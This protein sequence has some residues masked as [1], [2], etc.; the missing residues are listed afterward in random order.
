MIMYLLCSIHYFK[1]NISFEKVRDK[2]L[3]KKLEFLSLLDDDDDEYRGV[4]RENIV[5]FQ[6]ENN[7][8]DNNIQYKNQKV[9]YTNK[10]N[11]MEKEMT[12]LNNEKEK[13]NF[14]RHIR[15]RL[16][17]KA[18]D[19]SIDLR[20]NSREPNKYTNIFYNYKD[21]SEVLVLLRIKNGKKIGL[22]CNN[23][24]LYEQ[25]KNNN[26][27]S[28]YAGYIYINEQLFEI[29]LQDFF[30]KYGKYLQNIYDYLKSEYLRV[31]N[32]YNE[33]STRF[34]G[35]VDIFEIYQI[36]YIR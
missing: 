12:L 35:D 7:Y 14:K 20:Y 23:I 10:K 30:D 11:K 29:N 26:D 21:I 16:R 6:L 31:G 18:K 19:I 3:M 22:F 33:T 13:K 36:K 1:A 2:D 25:Y 28:N 4:I 5:D 8:D 24:L 15:R 9:I 17:H 34:L 27:D 32:R